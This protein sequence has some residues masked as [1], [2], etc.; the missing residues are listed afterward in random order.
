[1]E[2]TGLRERDI[3]GYFVKRVKAADPAG[4]L[5]LKFTPMGMAGF[6]D[7]IVLMWPGRAFFV[8]FKAPGKTMRPLQDKRAR[9]LENLGFKVYRDVDSF[10]KIDQIIRKE[11]GA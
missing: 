6:P 7:R 10:E 2:K 5:T 1:M 8:E 11:W 3:E 4:S 9:D